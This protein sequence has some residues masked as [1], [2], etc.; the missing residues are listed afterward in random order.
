MQFMVKLCSFSLTD[1]EGRLENTDH[2]LLMNKDEDV[3][4]N[5]KLSLADF[6]KADM[7]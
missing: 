5:W 6:F 3:S 4:V 7:F 1:V 2:F